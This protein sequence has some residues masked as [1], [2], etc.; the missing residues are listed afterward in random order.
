MLFF[1]I[2]SFIETML[3]LQQINLG[4]KKMITRKWKGES[5]T[6]GFL[7]YLAARKTGILQKNCQY[8]V[9]HYLF[10]TSNTS[11]NVATHQ[12]CKLTNKLTNCTRCCWNRDMLS[13]FRGTNLIKTGISSYTWHS[14][15]ATKWKPTKILQRQLEPW[16]IHDQSDKVFDK[17]YPIHSCKR[18]QLKT[19]PK[20]PV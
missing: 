14:C 4:K 13:L 1:I 5:S 2:E 9:V 16:T 12:L 10:F 11:N 19:L 18:L 7:F 20:I 8:H 17:Q 6:S 15:D 3:V